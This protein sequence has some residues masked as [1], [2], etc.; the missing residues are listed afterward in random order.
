MKRGMILFASILL[1][2]FTL[3]SLT[4]TRKVMPPEERLGYIPSPEFTSISSLEYRLLVSELL[5]YKT[6]FYFGSVSDRP[7]K[8]PDYK[9]MHIFLDTSTQLNPY[10]IDSYY[11][12]QA[13]LTWDAG[14]I[15]EVN[16]L[17]ERGIT[18]RTWDFYLPLFLGF[19]YSYF[20]GEYEKAAEYYAR[21]AKLNP[22]D[23]F[24][25]TLSARYLYQANKTEQAIEY[26]KSLYVGMSKNESV[27][28]PVRMR[29]D[30][31]ERIVFLEKGV[32][33]FR[34]RT[35]NNPGSL[36]DLVS[37]GILKQ[38]PPDPYGGRF[39]LDLR[40]GRVKTTSNLANPEKMR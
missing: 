8:K 19:N 38:I 32:R 18:K 1:C 35:G 34:E 26:L 39:F 6:T 10:N 13:I 40:D 16:P 28:K 3:V 33:M 29:I 20:L 36:E 2:G 7:G 4:Q 22:N 12:A 27:R 30:A 5:F 25:S 17:L 21:A 11:L 37:G 15:R 24:L 9:R 23:S 14:M 31:L